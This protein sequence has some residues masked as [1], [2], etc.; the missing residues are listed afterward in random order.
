MAA[1]NDEIRTL[2]QEILSRWEYDRWRQGDSD[3]FAWL[4][5]LI[6]KLSGW[7]ENLRIQS[8]ELHLLLLVGL[9]VVLLLLF[10]H[11]FWTIRRSL[12]MPVPHD[13]AAF[14][15]RTLTDFAAKAHEQAGQGNFLEAAHLMQL[16]TLESMLEKGVVD[17]SRSDPNQILRK[18][19]AE[20][21]LPDDLRNDFLA[22]LNRLE[23]SWFRD[24]S[25]D[26]VLYERWQALYQRIHGIEVAA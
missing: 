26:P 10:A 15:Q 13:E 25:G 6:R 20:S 3:L 17:L 23:R 5:D 12:A 22:Q 4:V 8:P 2:A 14:S 11:I 24:R 16:A 18:R 1:S 19:I 21:S 7:L 9:V